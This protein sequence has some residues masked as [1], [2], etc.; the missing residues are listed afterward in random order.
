MYQSLILKKK[1]A[2]TMDIYTFK[3]DIEKHIFLF[4]EKLVY[5]SAYI[6]KN[7]SNSGGNGYATINY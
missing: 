6:R 3:Y 1:K 2:A 7:Q 4:L 5:N